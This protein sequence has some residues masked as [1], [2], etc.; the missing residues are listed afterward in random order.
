MSTSGLLSG[1]PNDT[2]T[3]SFTAQAEDVT[4]SSDEQLLTVT[5]GPAFICGDANAD[6]AINIF[7]VTYIITYLYLD[8]PPPLPLESADIDNSGEIN[9]FD[10]TGLINYL[11]NGGPDPVCP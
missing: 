11:Y 4:G 1:T 8:G 10:V 2:G 7:D 3:I 6:L 5:V 9:I